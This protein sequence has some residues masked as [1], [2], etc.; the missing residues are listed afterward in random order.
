M[1]DLIFTSETKPTL[2]EEY[3][4][5]PLPD[6][7]CATPGC[8]NKRVAGSGRGRKPIYCEEHRKG[9]VKPPNTRAVKDTSNDRLANDAA[10]SLVFI[11]NF[12]GVAIAGFGLAGT[13]RAL[14][15]A[16]EDFRTNAY[17]SLKHNPALAKKIL[18]LGNRAGGASLALAY[19]MLAMSVAPIAALEIRAKRDAAAEEE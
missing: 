5:T 3:D 8:A 16:N 11:N 6:D 15:I 2:V 1:D 10:A 18:S 17:E 12:A 13:S 4:E 7:Q 14:K 9:G 19:V